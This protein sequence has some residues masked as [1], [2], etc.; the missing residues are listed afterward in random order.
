MYMWESE[1]NF[2][3]HSFLS[4]MKTILSHIFLT[5]CTETPYTER[6][7]EYFSDMFFYEIVCS[8][9]TTINNL[10]KIFM[11]PNVL[12]FSINGFPIDNWDISFNLSDTMQ[13]HDYTST[14]RIL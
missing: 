4:M 5:V 3:A 8:L 2:N 1:R 10:P 7:I 6:L 9:V 12:S 11:I 14:D 13:W